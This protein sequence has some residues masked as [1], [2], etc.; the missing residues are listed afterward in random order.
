MSPKPSAESDTDLRLHMAKAFDVDG[1]RAVLNATL[2]GHQAGLRPASPDRR[3]TIGPWPGQ[4]RGVLMLNGLGTRG[5]LVGPA[6]AKHLVHWWLDGISLPPEVRAERFK[7]VRV[8]GH[9]F[10]E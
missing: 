2:E 8:A 10:Q 9:G 7:T 6:M 4:P 5:V 3:P 1:A